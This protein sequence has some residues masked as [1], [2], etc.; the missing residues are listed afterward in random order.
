MYRTRNHLI[1]FYLVIALYGG[2]IIYIHRDYVPIWDGWQFY[3]QCLMSFATTADCSCF[4]H[5]A[6]L[7]TALYGSLAYLFPYSI[8]AYASLNLILGLA[9]CYS[10]LSW[11]SVNWNFDHLALA[12]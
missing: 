2:Y 9:A 10:L 5:T 7:P 12:S 1:L 11:F 4:D 6:Y 3:K 8:V